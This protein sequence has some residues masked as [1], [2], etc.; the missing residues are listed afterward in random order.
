MEAGRI[1]RGYWTGP[2]C[3]TRDQIVKDSAEPQR[4]WLHLQQIDSRKTRRRDLQA[5]GVAQEGG[6]YQACE[7]TAGKGVAYGRTIAQRRPRRP[8]DRLAITSLTEANPSLNLLRRSAQVMV[9]S[10]VKKTSRALIIMVIAHVLTHL[11]DP[12]MICYIVIY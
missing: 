6:N 9:S 7:G 11:K 8:L 10:N 5:L 1:I 12:K 4:Q 2:S 3:A